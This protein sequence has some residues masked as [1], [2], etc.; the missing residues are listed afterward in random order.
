M[1]LTITSVPLQEVIKL[2]KGK[3]VRGSGGS[4]FSFNYLDM[5]MFDK[6][7]KFTNAIYCTPQKDC[8]YDQLRETSAQYKTGIETAEA[9]G[10]LLVKSLL[11]NTCGK[12]DKNTLRYIYTYMHLRIDMLYLDRHL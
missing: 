7:L 4:V 2:R 11:Y 12:I 3:V 8:L 10:L 5:P 6:I 9:L 1:L